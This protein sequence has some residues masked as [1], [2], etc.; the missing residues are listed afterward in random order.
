M[1]DFLS[2]SHPE[3]EE[4]QQLPSQYSAPRQLQPVS[5]NGYS[6]IPASEDDFRRELTACLALSAASGMGEDDRT[7]WL[8]AAWGTLNGLPADLLQRGCNAARLKADHPSKI[9]P[10][11]VEEIGRTWDWRKRN[12]DPVGEWRPAE[13]EDRP[14]PNYCT[15]EEARKI[16]EEFGL[17]KPKD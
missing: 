14:D 13:P 5:A 8:R 16:L 7:E 15:A 11:I 10:A 6:L 4:R 2:L 12:P 9:V 3:S 1:E 17:R